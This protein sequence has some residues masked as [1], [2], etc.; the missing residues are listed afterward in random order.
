MTTKI[1]ACAMVVALFASTAALPVPAAAQTALNSSSHAKVWSSNGKRLFLSANAVYDAGLRRGRANS[2]H[3]A[4]LRGFRDGTGSV[5]Y[6]SGGYV[7]NRYENN[8]IA[9]APYAGYRLYDRAPDYAPAVD[10]YSSYGDSYGVRSV[11]YGDGYASAR[12]D[13]GYASDR[14]DNRYVPPGLLNVA[15]APSSDAQ[16]AHW[17]YCTAR[18]STFDPTS[19][20]FL[21]SDGNRYYCQ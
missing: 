11:P 17:N 21:A 15:A 5:A 10:T 18:Y 19:N 13:I 12:Y 3:N 20:T 16:V 6:N 9:E 14:Y 4:Y 2:S 7:V 8:R 1:A